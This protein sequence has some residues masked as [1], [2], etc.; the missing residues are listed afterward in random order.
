MMNKSEMLK[1]L[2]FRY[3]RYGVQK[4][5]V[6]AIFNGTID[7]ILECL[8]KGDDVSIHQLGK[9]AVKLRPARKGRNPQTGEEKTIPAQRVVKF[10]PCKTLREMV[11]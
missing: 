4:Q 6:E 3:A 5:D 1:K 2:K 10:L 11:K 9:F 7:I 8:K